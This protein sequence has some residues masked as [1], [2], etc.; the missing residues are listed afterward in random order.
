MIVKSPGRINIIGEHTD[1]SGGYVLPAAINFYT[2]IILAPSWR[3]ESRIIAL[4]FDEEVLITSDTLVGDLP[5]HWAKLFLGALVLSKIRQRVNV[6]FYGN[7]LVGA[8]MS[9]SASIS[10][11]FLTGLNTIFGLNK[12]RTTIAKTA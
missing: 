7:V 1:Y 9:S 8:G 2:T 4:D 10:C 12:D 6:L 3:P 11:G 5:F